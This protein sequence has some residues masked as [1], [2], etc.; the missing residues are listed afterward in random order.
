MAFLLFPYNHY[1]LAAEKYKDVYNK[2]VQ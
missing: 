2:L 1:K